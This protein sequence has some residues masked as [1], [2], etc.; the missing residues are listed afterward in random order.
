MVFLHIF[1]SKHLTFC[2]EYLCPLLTKTLFPRYNPLICLKNNREVCQ[3]EETL[4]KWV[5]KPKDED[6]LSFGHTLLCHLLIQDATFLLFSLHSI[7]SLLF[8]SILALCSCHFLVIFKR[9]RFH[10]SLS[11][12]ESY[13][14]K[15]YQTYLI[16]FLKLNI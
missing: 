13:L 11:F 6:Q 3:I 1:Q 15:Y 7:P 8:S 2:L 12:T 16:Y 9:S 14:Q 10:L 5:H 4:I